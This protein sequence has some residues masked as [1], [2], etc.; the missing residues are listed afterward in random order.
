MYSPFGAV[1]SPFE[2]LTIPVDRLMTRLAM[3]SIRSPADNC[4]ALMSLISGAPQ[5]LS[6]AQ[7]T[8]ARMAFSLECIKSVHPTIRLA[9]AVA[10]PILANAR[11]LNDFQVAQQIAKINGAFAVLAQAIGRDLAQDPQRLI[12]AQ[13]ANA[14]IV[15]LD[16]FRAP[17]FATDLFA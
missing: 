3:N 10:Y 2:T 16:P 1:E 14:N 6:E 9:D 12:L 5:G 17:V 4:I 8:Y 15:Y 11:M 7:L 13:A